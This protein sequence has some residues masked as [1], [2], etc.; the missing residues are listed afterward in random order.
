MVSE[1]T[2]SL[3]D[4]S[5][6]TPESQKLFHTAQGMGSIWSSEAPSRANQWGKSVGKSLSHL[7]SRTLNLSTRVYQKLI[8]E[9]NPVSYHAR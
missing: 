7:H 4:P 3:A 9:T 2:L 5:F 8:F 1:K 6:Q